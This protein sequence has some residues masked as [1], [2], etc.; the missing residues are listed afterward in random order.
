MQR[1]G[2]LC[3]LSR[4]CLRQHSPTSPVL[5]EPRRMHGNS[6]PSPTATKKA[7]LPSAAQQ[8]N[9][10]VWWI[11]P[12]SELP[13]SSLSLL[14]STS[15]ASI[16]NVGPMLPADRIPVDQPLLSG[17]QASSGVLSKGFSCSRTED[18]RVG[19]VVVSDTDADLRCMFGVGCN[20]SSDEPSQSLPFYCR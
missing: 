16:A 9:N 14:S 13:S 19:G 10:A 15:Q 2:S 4:L 20:K 8:R 1:A 5:L 18:E 17:S 3:I 12:G 7:K 6:V 11:D